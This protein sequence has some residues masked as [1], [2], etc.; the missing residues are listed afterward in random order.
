M[1]PLH[2]ITFAFALGVASLAPAQAASPKDGVD[3]PVQI[4]GGGTVK[5]QLARVERTLYSEDYSEISMAEKSS[6]SA[7]INR[8]RIRV[9]EH[10]SVEAL[11]PQAQTEV[12]NDE[13]L[14]NQ[15]LSRAHADSR[16]VCRR[17]RATGTNRPERVCLTVAQRKRM[18][19]ESQNRLQ[20]S[21]RV[22][23]SV[24]P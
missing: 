14:I 23:H 21:Q 10:D 15:I 13:A 1:K 19:E 2:C 3:G 18:Q 7:A 4:T 8:I 17:E 22:P 20:N 24:L 5:D 16:M 11:N 6:V 9:G 12:K